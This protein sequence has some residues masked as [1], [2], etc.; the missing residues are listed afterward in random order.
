AFSHPAGRQD[1]DL[2][3]MRNY[4]V[5]DPMRHILWKTIAR[6]HRPLVRT[7]E[8]AIAPAPITVAFLVAG[9]ADEPTAAT[10]RLYLERGMFGPDFLF[11]ADGP[12]PPPHGT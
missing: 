7:P 4:G 9:A 12:A 6:T 3:E 1:G 2:V 8:R 11:A 10:A 5:G